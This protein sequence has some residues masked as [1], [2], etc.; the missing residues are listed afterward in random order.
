MKNLDLRAGT[1]QAI[2]KTPYEQITCSMDFSQVAGSGGIGLVSVTSSNAASG[3]DT[4]AT[5][6]ATSPVPGVVTGT[7]KIVFLLQGGNNGET[8]RI[9]VTAN[10]PAAGEEWE[11]VVLVTVLGPQ[12]R[13]LAG[14]GI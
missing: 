7:A 5:I 9:S 13:T 3:A 14:D 8:H 4:T 11:G 6:I 1:T 12:K 10:N 2:I